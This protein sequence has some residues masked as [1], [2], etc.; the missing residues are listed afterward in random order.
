MPKEILL[1]MIRKDRVPHALLFSGQ[2][3]VGKKLMAMAFAQRLLCLS[4]TGCG[5]CMSC[6][7]VEKGV[8]PDLWLMA[9]EDSIG[10]DEVR[11][12]REKG[13]RGI[14]QEV[15]EHPMEGRRRVIIIDTAERM[16]R[17]AT[18]ALLKTLEEPPIF[19][20]F[21]LVTASEK[22]IPRTIRSRCVRVSFGPL[23][24]AALKE[25]FGQA[26]KGDGERAEMLSAISLGSIATGLFW[27]REDNLLF[28]RRLAAL[29]AGREKSYLEATSIAERMSTTLLGLS[30]YLNFLLSLLRDMFVMALLGDLSMTVNRDM[31]EILETVRHDRAWIVSSMKSVQ[32][33]LDDLRY[34]VN[35]WA[36][37]ED[38]LLQI[39]RLR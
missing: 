6:R 25:F 12:S 26:L 24:E 5:T 8:H 37:V 27:A 32:Q 22:D 3:G 18:N 9:G 33:A 20:V 4:Q 39:M 35:R 19:N 11:G 10:V 21:I 36:L 1:A 29:I 7:K 2:E 13:V 15:Y 30:I 38:L 23:P 28:R 17:E 34:N 16:T 31:R 14:N